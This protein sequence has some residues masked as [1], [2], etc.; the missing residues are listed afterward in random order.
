MTITEL[1][2]LAEIVS[3]FGVIA[4]LIFV[5]LEIRKG[6][7]Q[8]KLANW[9]S[10]VDRYNAVYSQTDDIA[11]ANLV[12]KGRK[13]Y[14]DLTEGEKISF[15]HYLEQLCIANEALLV[16][17]QTMVHGKEDA[18][19]VF[20]K[21]ISFHLGFKGSREWLED[22]ESERS[23]PAPLMRAIHQAIDEESRVEVE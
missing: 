11:L 12:A 6:T 13:S 17:A 10:L 9:A 8:S 23:F 14:R 5:A 7:A 1:A 2:D 22:F 15:G 19:A 3:G 20:R 4:S 16:Y 18:L 21:Q